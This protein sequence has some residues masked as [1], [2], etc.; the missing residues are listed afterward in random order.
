MHTGKLE[1]NKTSVD[2]TPIAFRGKTFTAKKMFVDGTH[3]IKPPQETLETIQ[4]YFEKIQLTR[5]ADITGLDRIGIPVVLSI[6]P[7]AKMLAIDSGKGFDLTA[8]TVSAAMESLERYHGDFVELPYEFVTYEQLQK[9]YNT[10]PVDRLLLSRYSIFSPKVPEKWTMGWDLLNQEE[11][12][13]P[14]ELVVGPHCQTGPS[15]GSFYQS[16]N[17]LASGNHFIEA[18]C[19][20]LYEV[21]ERDSIGCHHLAVRS[22]NYRPKRMDIS[23]L[24]FPLVKRLTDKVEAAEC[25]LVLYDMTHDTEIPIFKALIYDKVVHSIGNCGGYGAHLDPEIAMVRAITEAIQS[26][27]VFIAG[28]RDDFYS[29]PFQYQRAI[30]V[31][32]VTSLRLDRD[33][34]VPVPNPIHKVTSAFESDLNILLK[35]VRA[36]GIK[37]VIVNDLTLPGLDVS[38]V[39]VS[40]PGMESYPSQIYK[41]GP[42]AK[43]FLESFA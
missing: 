20:G 8:A 37:Q 38:V 10:I 4:P 30:D 24:N 22:P 31:N 43:K 19:A 2:R 33:Q 16:T 28:S 29:L 7:N 41:P 6:R 23:N 3:R 15:L 36:I 27:A 21:I 39:K 11:V 9:K 26:R 1:D 34:I 40:V 12:P 18:V 13:V 42:R 35:Q 14:L 25:G 5:L 32:G 17:G